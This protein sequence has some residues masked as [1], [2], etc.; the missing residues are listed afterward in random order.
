MHEFTTMYHYFKGISDSTPDKSI[1]ELKTVVKKELSLPPEAVDEMS[2]GD[3]PEEYLEMNGSGSEPSDNNNND[4]SFKAL[5]KENA[6][7]NLNY[8]NVTK[9]LA[10][11]ESFDC[12][13]SAIAMSIE[14]KVMKKHDSTDMLNN[15]NDLKIKEEDEKEIDQITNCGELTNELKISEPKYY[16]SNELNK[17]GDDFSNECSDVLDN[18]SSNGTDT[19]SLTPSTNSVLSTE[20][21]QVAI[22]QEEDYLIQP[23]NKPVSSDFGDYLTQPSNRPLT[24][25]NNVQVMQ[26]DYMNQPPS[27]SKIKR[28][29]EVSHLRLYFKKKT[30]SFNDDDGCGYAKIHELHSPTKSMKS[31]K[32]TKSTGTLKRQDSDISKKSVDDELLEIIN[33]FKN[34]VFTIQE[35]EELVSSWKNRN[36]VKKSFKDKQE[37]LQKMREEYERIQEKMND[38]LKRPSPFERMKR[39][40]SRKHDKE[41]S[42]TASESSD[43]QV[44]RPVSSTLSLNSA[45]S[46]SSGRMSTSSQVSQGDSGTHSDHDERR[47][48]NGCN[49]SVYRIGHPGSLMDNYLI[50]P[51]PRPISTASTPND[52][53]YFPSNSRNFNPIDTPEH[54]IMFPSNMPV[55]PTPPSSSSIDNTFSTFKGSN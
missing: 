38:N 1:I 25:Y 22:I 36:D 7:A 19:A 40:F 35:V 37:Q 42:K 41:T 5:T 10:T 14:M 18:C 44:N 31:V 8:L 3:H 51:A 52:N 32:S 48:H 11:E 28:D 6:V 16:D 23:S 29:R 49:T 46:T 20:T 53:I 34:N 17:V 4:S 21:K 12:V 24:K 2:E 33:D 39:L 30:D 27:H 45:S 47:H 13:D 50:P 9:E 26:H 55:F 15:L 43:F 54:Y